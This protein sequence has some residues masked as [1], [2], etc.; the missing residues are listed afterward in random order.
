[1]VLAHYGGA[2][3]IAI[4]LVPAVLAL[5]ALRWVERRAKRDRSDDDP[6]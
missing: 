3:E 1:M 6:E 4:F 2:D 5:L